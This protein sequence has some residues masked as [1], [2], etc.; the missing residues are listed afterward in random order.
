MVYQAEKMEIEIPYNSSQLFP[1]SFVH[2]ISI[3]IFWLFSGL[4]IADLNPNWTDVSINMP[5]FSTQCFFFFIFSFHFFFFVSVDVYRGQGCLPACLSEFIQHDPFDFDS[6][7]PVL[8]NARAR[9]MFTMFCQMDKMSLPYIF[10]FWIFCR[11]PCTV[12]V[13]RTKLLNSNI[14]ITLFRIVLRNWKLIYI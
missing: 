5:Y 10:H 12:S 4:L 6:S 1:I 14:Y 9:H 7:E 2:P 3:E 11:V 13:I 8:L